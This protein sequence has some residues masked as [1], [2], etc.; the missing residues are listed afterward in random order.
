LADL[1]EF[2][3]L[4][5]KLEAHADGTIIE[6]M[7]SLSANADASESDPR[8]DADTAERLGIAGSVLL[9]VRADGHIGLRAERDHV[10]AMSAYL[11]RLR[12]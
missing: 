8:L 5:G 9:V 1:Q 12:A 7:L 10:A 2:A 11:E 6:R 3:I 4:S